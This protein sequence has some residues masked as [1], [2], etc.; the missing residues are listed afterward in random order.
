MEK[1]ELSKSDKVIGW[2]ATIL[3]TLAFAGFAYA[4]QFYFIG[5]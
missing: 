3:F 4:S 5:F 1:E 2:I